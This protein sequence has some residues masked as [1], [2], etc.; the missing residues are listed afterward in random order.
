MSSKCDTRT[1]NKK[2][3]PRR[4]RSSHWSR[5]CWKQVHWLCVYGLS[6]VCTCHVGAQEQLLEQLL[7]EADRRAQAAAAADPA[8]RTGPTDMADNA[9][10]STRSNGRASHSLCET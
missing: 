4:K 7:S 2:E 8:P 9:L 10:S 3:R 1:Q 5:A 6:C